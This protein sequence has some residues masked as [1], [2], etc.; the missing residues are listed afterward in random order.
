MPTL[1]SQ[2]SRYN[3]LVTIFVA[4]GSFTYGYCASIIG[5]TIGQ[6]G[7]YQ[8]FSLPQ[9][10]EPG[11]ATTTTNAIATANGLFSA[12]GALGALSIM[13]TCDYFGRKRNIQ[14]GSALSVLGGALQGG[15]AAL[16][17]FHVG[18]FVSGLG[19]GI[20]VTVC[21]QYLSEVSP[22]FVRGWLVGHHA[23]FLVFGY[24]LSAW[25][26]YA[27]YWATPVNPSFAWR[28]P[29]CMQCLAPALLLAGSPWVPRSP[30][31]LVS[32][33]KLDEAMTVLMR[34]RQSPGDPDN[35]VAREEFYQISEQLK[36]DEQKLKATGYGVWRV[37]WKKKSYRKRMLMGFM[38]QFGAEV[39]GPLIINNYAVILYTNL[40]QTGGMPLLLSA[41]W[42]TTA[43]L[44]YN[45]GGAWLHDKVNSRRGMFM[46]GIAGCLVTTACLCA[47]IAQYA[48]TTNRVGNG[49]GIFG[50]ETFAKPDH[51]ELETNEIAFIFLY[52]AFQGTGCDTTMYLWV[53]EIFP[54]EIRSIG[55]GF[56][57]F[58]QFA[59][60]LI[61]L[62]TAPIG[63]AQVG[64]KYFLLV[65]CWS[66]VFLPIIYFYFPET[67][68]L[69]LEEIAQKFG[70][71]V[72]VHIT[73]ASQEEQYKLEKMVERRESG[74]PGDETA[75]AVP[76][77]EPV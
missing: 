21:P 29:L 64:W 6:P 67:A 69:T 1:G 66:A 33:D 74:T 53:S 3:R 4:L 50:T 25:L 13:F 14:F 17:M 41:V 68:R 71:D 23:I 31:W 56:S 36:L 38:I 62:Q 40:G 10:G 57:L 45:P 77:R 48:G 44:I 76:D 8:Y 16:A 47:M 30:R 37:V 51:L 11:Y 43:G 75:H 26:G 34:L 55:M 63:F 35:L 15:A 42:L 61:V 39:A 2:T 7:W 22:P 73:D 19:I 18:R 32:K 46:V 59:A 65:V 58:G 9:Q 28:F 70:D 24:M 5:S 60:T 49:F 72:A 52:L 12:G 20:L 27:C 54:T